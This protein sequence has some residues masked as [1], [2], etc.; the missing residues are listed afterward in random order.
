MT[1][2][3]G[4][5]IARVVILTLWWSAVA[6]F[7]EASFGGH[8]FAPTFLARLLLLG[9]VLLVTEPFRRPPRMG[10]TAA[11]GPEGSGSRP[12]LQARP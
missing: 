1:R 7:L 6:A 3:L 8:D 5:R 4:P 12:S 10:F 11:G 9:T 2:H